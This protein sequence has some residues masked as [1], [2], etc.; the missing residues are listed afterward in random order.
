MLSEC[1]QK[2][3]QKKQ[4]LDALRP[5]PKE[6]IQNLDNWLK[7]D[8]TYNSNA[9]EGNTLSPSE[10]ALVVEKGL[11]IGGKSVVEHLEAI[12]HA[13]A[14]DYIKELALQKSPLSNAVIRDIHAL[15]LKKIDETYAGKWRSTQV[16]I[17][18]SDVKLADPIMVPELMQEFEGWLLSNS[19]H[20]VK[21]AADAHLKLVTIHPFIDGNGRTARL[22]MN[23]ILLQNGYPIAVI[24]NENRKA[25]I[26]ALEKAQKTRDATDFYEIIGNAVDR[27]LDLWLEAASK[28]IE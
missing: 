5:L 18:G 24:K 16:K 1:L 9:I 15:V 3:D 19:D 21:K 25:Y 20:P 4:K 6:L 28:T 22:L 13:Y 8:L 11:T 2:V 14:L 12:N 7:V 26:D 23:L 10:T 17:A 27:S